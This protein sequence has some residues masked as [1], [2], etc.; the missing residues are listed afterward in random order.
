MA[1][2]R[3]APF[4]CVCVCSLKFVRFD[5]FFGDF[6]V[7]FHGVADGVMSITDD[8]NRIDET[9][10][11]LVGRESHDQM[12]RQLA[13]ESDRLKQLS[14]AMWSEVQTV[15]DDRGAR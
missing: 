8:A 14:E 9:M 2:A 12:A 10:E 4:Y 3:S 5:L 11:R 7:F 13:T 15:I 1:G 6:A